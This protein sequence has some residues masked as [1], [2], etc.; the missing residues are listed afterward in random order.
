MV[1]IATLASVVACASV[2]E[3]GPTADEGEVLLVARL[4]RLE[5]SAYKPGPRVQYDE[6]GDLLFITNGCGTAE[7]DF[8][9]LAS[10]APLPEIVTY[11]LGIGEWCDPP[12]PFTLSRWLIVDNSETGYLGVFPLFTSGDRLFATESDFFLLTSRDPDTA[13]LPPAEALPEP[14]PFFL[15]YF[16]A[17]WYAEEY[18][19]LERIGDEL[20][21][22]HGVPVAAIFPELVPDTF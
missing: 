20:M 22:V 3:P 5:L 2:K 12:I 15:P 6:H 8:H 7:A 17:A 14:V 4:E 9:V 1:C 19:D 16:D 13:S 21:I 11:T 10:T 18:A